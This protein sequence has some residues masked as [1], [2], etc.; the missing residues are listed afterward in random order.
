[1]MDMASHSV[2]RALRPAH[3][4][5][6]LTSLNRLPAL[7]RSASGIARVDANRTGEKMAVGSVA[8][9]T[10]ARHCPNRLLAFNPLHPCPF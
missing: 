6:H 2:S 5:S 7:H 9:A 8:A 4:H 10:S 3:T 1:M